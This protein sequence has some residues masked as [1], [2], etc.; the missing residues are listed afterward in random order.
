MMLNGDE[1]ELSYR[2]TVNVNDVVSPH[3]GF[4]LVD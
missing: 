1:W 4:T 3:G 2:Y